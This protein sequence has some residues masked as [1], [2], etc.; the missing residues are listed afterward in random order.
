[1]VKSADDSSEFRNYENRIHQLFLTKA[2]QKSYLYFTVAPRNSAIL[3]FFP[4]KS[5]SYWHK[6]RNSLSFEDYK[7]KVGG[8]SCH[9]CVKSW[10][11][12]DRRLLNV[13]ARVFVFTIDSKQEGSVLLQKQHTQT[14]FSFHFF[15]PSLSAARLNLCSYFETFKIRVTTANRLPGKSIIMLIFHRK[16]MQAGEKVK[17]LKITNRKLMAQWKKTQ[18]IMYIR[19][20]SASCSRAG[21][22]ATCDQTWNNKHPKSLKTQNGNQRNNMYVFVVWII[23]QLWKQRTYCLR[24]NYT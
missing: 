21:C 19:L 1:M 23:P 10:W 11:K 17:Q 15:R 4:F 3:L 14:F 16:C 18:N 9:L 8:Q 13:F 6:R 12:K 2:Q 7:K 24:K 20:K 5:S 22:H